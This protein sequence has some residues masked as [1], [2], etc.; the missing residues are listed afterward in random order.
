MQQLDGLRPARLKV[1]IISAG[2]VGSA[3]GAALERVDH[4]V[5]A[6]TARSE[7]SRRFA[8]DRLPDTLIRSPE[9]VAADSELLILA[10]PD[11]ELAGVV[12]DLVHSDAVAP[13]TIVVHTS[14]AAGI[15]V[16]APLAARGATPLAIHPAM[17]FTGSDDDIARLTG[18][19]FGITAADEIGY[20]VAAALVWE[21]G[22]EPMRVAD[23]ARPLYHAAL[24][25]ASN[26]LVTVIAD[27]MDMLTAALGSPAP[28]GVPVSRLVAPLA[29]AALE[30]ALT[31]GDGALT[32]P[33][34]R[35]DADA[36]AAHL[37]ALDG[38]SPELMQAYRDLSR[39]TA[40]RVHA[41]PEIFEVLDR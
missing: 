23:D 36:V 15:G 6:A 33:V 16:L 27:A 41:R 31:R 4:V 17:T 26:H 12:A 38:A 35:G 7:T 37:R 25:Q 2:R 18:C 20:A 29:R 5:V 13:A 3:I 40:T 24:A 8:A 19:C 14:G 39:R 1:G 21:L 9:Q 22:G 11:T 32:G 30:N 34:A 28:E 10:V